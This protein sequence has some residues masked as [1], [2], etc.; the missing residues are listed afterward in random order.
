[1]ETLILINCSVI[2]ALYGL[3]TVKF[4]DRLKNNTA[5]QGQV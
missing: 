3:Q 4:R 2:N 5:A 1:M